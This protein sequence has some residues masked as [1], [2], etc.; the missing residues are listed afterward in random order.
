MVLECHSPEEKARVQ[1]L[2]DFVV[3]GT[4]TVGSFL[5]GGLL[6]SFGWSTVLV[7]SFAPLL[8]AFL[9]LIGLSYRRTVRQN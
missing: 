1:S 7:L 8:T 5:S 3:F 4:M 9:A 6:S 2:N